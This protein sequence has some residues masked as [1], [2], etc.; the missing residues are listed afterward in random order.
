M[1]QVEDNASTQKKKTKLLKSFLSA[2]IPQWERNIAYSVLVLYYNGVHI[3]DCNWYC[4]LGLQF[5]TSSLL[6][7]QFYKLRLCSFNQLK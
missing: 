5:L 7:F 2:N 6:S 3:R 4:I 1:E